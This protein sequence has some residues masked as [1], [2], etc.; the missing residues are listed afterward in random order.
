MCAEAGNGSRLRY[1]TLPAI[2]LVPWRVQAAAV[3]REA[4]GR[5]GGQVPLVRALLPA[6]HVRV[7]ATVGP[8][9]FAA[10]G[11]AVQHHHDHLRAGV[12]TPYDCKRHT[13]AHVLPDSSL[14]KKTSLWRATLRHKIMYDKNVSSSEQAE[15]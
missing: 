2:P 10:R 1:I 9:A 13:G 3:H 5:D 7:T 15:Y 8:A 6:A 14:I 4:A 11:P 12:G